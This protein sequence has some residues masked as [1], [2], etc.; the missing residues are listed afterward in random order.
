MRL[1]KC[2]LACS[3]SALLLWGLTIPIPAGGG[4]IP[5]LGHFFNPFSGFWKNAES[6]KSPMPNLADA[7]P[8][9]QAPVEVVFDDLMVPH[10]FAQNLH[11]ALMVQGYI[12]ASHRLWQMDISSR[13][14]SGRLSEVLGTRT[15]ELDLKMRRRGMVY[16]A[17]N[18]LEAWK[19]SPESL[20]IMD[21][22]CAGVNAWIDNLD[23]ANYPLEFKLLG[24]K[25]ETWTPLHSALMLESMADN[26]ASG[27][28]DLA[29]SN[30]LAY[31]GRDTFN[32]LYPEWNPKQSPVVPDT[33]QWVN[34]K[35]PVS[36]SDPTHSL[37]S[38]AL[39]HADGFWGE[40]P[41][42]IPALDA[43]L[44]GSNNWALAADK[45]RDGNPLLA[46]DP[47]LNL[48]LPSIWYQLQIHIPDN[49]SYGISLPGIPGIIIGFNN[50]IAWGV[51]NV[52]HDVS[53]WYRITWTDASRQT[54]L[55][56]G[57]KMTPRMEIQVVKVRG[58]A[59]VID[60]LRFTR[61]GPLTNEH[62]PA[63]PLRDHALRWLTHDQPPPTQV[64]SF[65]GLNKSKDYNGYKA[66][67]P[68]FDCPAQNFVFASTNGDIAIQ[69][70][71]K[72]PIRRK[73]QGRFLLDGSK[74]ADTWSGFI[75]QE[76]V[77]S[78]LNP[79][80]GFVSSANQHSTPPTY[81]YYYTGTFDDFRGRRINGRLTGM[82]NAT[83]DSMKNMQL[84]NFSQKAAD[85]LPTMLH[86]LD[87]S[88]L[89]AE[90][91]EMFAELSRW[92]Y[93]YD[94]DATAAPFFEV[95]FDSLYVGTWDEM[96]YLKEQ[97]KEIL[98]PKPWRL[99]ELMQT[100]SAGVF[101]DLRSTPDV[102]ETAVDMVNI[103]FRQM[104]GYFKSHPEKQTDWAS[105]RGFVIKHLG[106]ID[107]FGRSDVKVGGHKS[108]P[109][110][111]AA[112]NGPSWRMIVELD[113]PVRA[114]GVYPG[115]QSGNPGSMYYD[116]M[117]N[118]W[119]SG[120]YFDLL[121][122]QSSGEAGKRELARHT[123]QPSN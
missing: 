58:Q 82:Q 38:G 110:A 118:T 42:N 34:I 11:D 20:A 92:D 113:K 94:A 61:W 88:K 76:H 26:L 41:I 13:R 52:S 27:E 59:D 6:E 56:D 95:W 103:S 108:A 2:L 81:P 8:G 90:G 32:Y 10:I 122:L 117:V 25:P 22:Y 43:Y 66:S 72:Y 77:P 107:A 87:P 9:L 67:I 15:L 28:N 109:N 123:F 16:A 116:N 50:D 24:Y 64:L 65:L 100:D 93:R 14:A 112:S 5:P 102:K 31:F 53:D 96:M 121:F 47:H 23:P 49:N 97:Q 80:R 51:T 7:L 106:L 35:S 30:A 91:R 71:G 98:F 86:Y 19:K 18:E 1:L 17:Q 45:T 54:Y 37:L 115:G 29:S 12:T 62:N 75:P 39:S 101:F 120:E 119:A 57:K 111:M 89:D 44:Y 69:P 79:S 83:I 105:F 48:T 114:L 21:A 40:N 68:S 46:N 60:T 104:A 84:D 36:G 63:H 55:V 70:Q 74:G 73:E 3:L 78:M 33:G 4:T 85:V 99:I